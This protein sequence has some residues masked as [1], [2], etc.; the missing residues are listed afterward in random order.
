[1]RC[2]VRPV[3]LDGVDCENIRDLFGARKPFGVGLGARS[4]GPAV[5]VGGLGRSGV[6]GH[7][8]SSLSKG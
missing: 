2:G 6:H 5:L 7:G 8:G 4:V 3:A 1:M